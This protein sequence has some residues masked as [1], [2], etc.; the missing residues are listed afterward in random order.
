MARCV[1]GPRPAGALLTAADL[2]LGSRWPVNIQSRDQPPEVPPHQG[3]QHT[4]Q[5]PLGVP[6]PVPGQAPS[7]PHR[8]LLRRWA[9]R[10]KCTAPPPRPTSLLGLHSASASPPGHRL[11]GLPPPV[12]GPPGHTPLISVTVRAPFVLI[13]ALTGSTLAWRRACLGQSCAAPLSPPPEGSLCWRGEVCILLAVT[14]EGR[15]GREKVGLGKAP[16]PMREP[17]RP[18]PLQPPPSQRPPSLHP[19][20]ASDLL[21]PPQPHWPSTPRASGGLGALAGWTTRGGIL[22]GVGGPFSAQHEQPGTGEGSQGWAGAP[23]ACPSKEAGLV[24]QGA[25]QVTETQKDRKNAGAHSLTFG[26]AR[27]PASENTGTETPEGQR[28]GQPQSQEPRSGR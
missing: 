5:Y 19:S 18:R 8:Q 22:L 1:W 11:R 7:P 2:V 4:E 13:S 21:H 25:F 14:R 10:R 16:R 28:D 15:V 20:H 9:Q 27:S 17:P 3:G 6:V 26:P 24:P 12:P 23:S